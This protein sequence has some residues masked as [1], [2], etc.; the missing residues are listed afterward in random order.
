MTVTFRA[1]SRDDVPAVVALLS[2]DALGRSRETDDPA[3][4]LAAFDAMQAEGA[5]HLIIGTTGDEVVACYQI[6][7]ISGL[8]LTASRRAQIEG[9]RVAGHLRGQ[10]IG[11][12]LIGDAE[13]RARAAGCT[14]LQFTTN[15]SRADAHRFY[16]RLGFTP[17]HIG[18]K[19]SL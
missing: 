4:Y 15:K 8:S 1:A 2:D 3:P 9:V 5:N 13:A 19:K 11:E 12:A 18:Y 10:R 17:S 6:T 16:D 14:L 7:F